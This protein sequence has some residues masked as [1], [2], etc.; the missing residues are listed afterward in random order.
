[1]KRS[2]DWFSFS[3]L[4][5]PLHFRGVNRKGF[6]LMSRFVFPFS[7]RKEWIEYQ[8]GVSLSTQT[9]KT[10]RIQFVYSLK[11]LFACLVKT[12]NYGLYYLSYLFCSCMM[13]PRLCIQGHSRSL[14]LACWKL[15][16]IHYTVTSFVQQGNSL[17][18]KILVCSQTEVSLCTT[19]DVPNIA[20][21]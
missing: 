3:C 2:S 19:V 12:R 14:S 15:L 17:A 13:M 20:R 4:T 16:I 1:M 8:G 11:T 5:F 18:C 10:W 7:Q 9:N 21:C 6:W